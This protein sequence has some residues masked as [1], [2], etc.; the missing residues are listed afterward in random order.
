MYGNL[1]PS[2]FLENLA[3]EGIPN[4]ISGRRAW[5]AFIR[6]WLTRV[7]WRKA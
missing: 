4:F 3:K 1:K 5:M 6:L 7:K 2:V